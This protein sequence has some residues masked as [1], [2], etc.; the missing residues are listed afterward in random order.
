MSSAPNDNLYFV[1]IPIV[2]RLDLAKT[3][4]PAVI[5]ANL[6]LITHSLMSLMTI[7]IIEAFENLSQDSYNA[8]HP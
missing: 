5:E 6:V 8:Q 4:N 1:Y 3:S 2:A 7:L